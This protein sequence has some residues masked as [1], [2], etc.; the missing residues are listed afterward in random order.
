MEKPTVREFVLREA[1][2]VF[3][4]LLEKKISFKAFVNTMIRKWMCLFSDPLTNIISS[5]MS[6]DSVA[7]NAYKTIILKISES[8]GEDAVIETVPINDKS[9]IKIC[10]KSA[11]TADDCDEL[12]KS[13]EEFFK[14]FD[15]IYVKVFI[16]E[17]P[18]KLLHFGDALM[19]VSVYV[20]YMA[21]RLFGLQA[22]AKEHYMD[23]L[24]DALTQEFITTKRPALKRKRDDSADE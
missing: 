12:F 14:S 18:V 5:L 6:D 16:D 8:F 11:L 22:R 10:Q 19:R 23:A 20:Q 2:P 21:S 3:C 9:Y 15:K 24:I 17:E 13:P 1:A 4:D 7:N